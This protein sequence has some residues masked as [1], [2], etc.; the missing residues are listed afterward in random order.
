LGVT[1]VTSAVFVN[2]ADGSIPPAALNGV[3]VDLIDFHC[4]GQPGDVMLYLA[5]AA[6]FTVFDTQVI[7]QIPE[8]ITFALLGLGG[9]FLRRRK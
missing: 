6:V 2:L 1:G 7:H 9:L 5:E 3:L 4:T 8:P